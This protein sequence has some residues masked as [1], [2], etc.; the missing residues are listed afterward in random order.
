M[1]KSKWLILAV[2]RIKEAPNMY[3]NTP[4]FGSYPIQQA[5]LFGLYEAFSLS[6]ETHIELETLRSAYEE[7]K[8]QISNKKEVL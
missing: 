2:S 6:A 1:E 3:G 5:Y 7:S 8:F 4:D